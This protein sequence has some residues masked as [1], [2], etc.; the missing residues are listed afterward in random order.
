MLTARI[1]LQVLPA[2]DSTNI[3]FKDYM[4]DTNIEKNYLLNQLT[5]FSFIFCLLMLW[6]LQDTSFLIN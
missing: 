2:L 4:F 1:A 6:G 5:S 3:I